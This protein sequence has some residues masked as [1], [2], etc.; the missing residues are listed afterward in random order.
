MKDDIDYSQSL[1]Y[2]G[3]VKFTSEDD[4]YAFNEWGV[5]GG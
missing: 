5:I 1:F 2:H 4:P 3:F